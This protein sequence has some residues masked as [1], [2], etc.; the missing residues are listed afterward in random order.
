MS[1]VPEGV[2]AEL[3]E[4][5]WKLADDLGWSGLSD[6]ERSGYYAAWTA[7]P[8]IGGVLS[9]H[10]DPRRVRVYIK[11]TLLKPYLMARREESLTE[12]LRRL[13]LDPDIRPVERFIKPLGWRLDDGR[14]FCWGTPRDWKLVL[15]SVYER[16]AL[17]PGARPYAAV[18]IAQ[19]RELGTAAIRLVADAGRRLGIER[20]EF[21]EPR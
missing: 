11:D 3:Q 17:A 16:A 15:M 1:K 6:L 10:I 4:L 20:V 7:S 19:G 12:V 18:F 13:S 8:S 2:R 9:R 21:M 14:V 5:L